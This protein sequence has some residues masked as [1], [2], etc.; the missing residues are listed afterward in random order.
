MQPRHA[1]RGEP[2]A[3]VGPGRATRVGGA[4]AP[5]GGARAPRAATAY[6][7]FFKAAA[8]EVEPARGVRGARRARRLRVEWGDHPAPPPVALNILE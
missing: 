6:G 3:P 1:P 5:G 2:R 7:F 4:R 8:L